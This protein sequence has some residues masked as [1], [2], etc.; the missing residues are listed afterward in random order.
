[1]AVYGLHQLSAAL[2][3]EGTMSAFFRD[4]N[5]ILQVCAGFTAEHSALHSTVN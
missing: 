1:M 4:K 5:H 2:R 3:A